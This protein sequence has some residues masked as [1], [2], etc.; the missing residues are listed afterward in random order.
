[1]AAI[2]RENV[3]VIAGETGSG[4]STQIPHFILQ[5]DM[6]VKDRHLHKGITHV[7]IVKKLLSTC[8]LKLSY[9][10][11]KFNFAVKHS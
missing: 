8:C 10:G 6:S 11:R 2:S 7:I 5:V 4:K 3:V 9:L 1:M